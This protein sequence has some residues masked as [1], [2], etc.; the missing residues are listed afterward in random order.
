MDSKNDIDMLPSMQCIAWG[1]G[2]HHTYNFLIQYDHLI[3]KFIDT[4]DDPDLLMQLHG[5]ISNI[6]FKYACIKGDLHYVKLMCDNQTKVN[7]IA[8]SSLAVENNHIDIIKHFHDCG[9]VMSETILKLAIRRR[10]LPIV[11]YLCENYYTDTHMLITAIESE[12]VDIV[13][14][15]LQ[16][17]IL[18]YCDY[19]CALLH[20]IGSNNYDIVKY[21]YE[22]HDGSDDCYQQVL[23]S[24]CIKSN[25]KIINYLFENLDNIQEHIH[26]ILC[27][28]CKHS[29]LDV[30]EYLYNK[31][32]DLRINDDEVLKIAIQYK[33][34]NV[35]KY[36]CDKGADFYSMPSDII[37]EYGITHGKFDIIHH[38]INNDIHIFDNFDFEPHLRDVPIPMCLEII[39][40]LYENGINSV[41]KLF[42]WSILQNNIDLVKYL[43]ECFTY[44]IN[45]SLLKDIIN[46]EETGYRIFMFLYEY[47]TINNFETN[48]LLKLAAFCGKTNTVK[49]LCSRGADVNTDD[50]IVFVYAAGSG[51]LSMMEYLYQQGIRIDL[52]GAAALRKAKSYNQIKIVH[53]L[54]NIQVYDD[55]DNSDLR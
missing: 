38:V 28:A 30:I 5:E 45:F 54:R 2:N 47:A 4:Y 26:D 16:I 48:E 27:I 8:A 49:Y 40:T 29:R 46:N 17:G 21:I 44:E 22:N 53:F 12:S 3:S 37:L 31:G 11:V 13:Q 23:Q 50:G 20:A 6:I 43:Y 34:S 42:M 10:L 14:Y 41:Q 52:Y 33:R 55:S 7:I 39:K 19:N 32:V 15:F 25:I 9:F 51:Q 18:P 35:V 24:A 1:A 36:L